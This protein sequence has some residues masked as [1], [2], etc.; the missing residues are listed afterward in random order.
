MIARAGRGAAGLYRYAWYLGAAFQIQD[1]VLNLVGDFEQYGKEPEGDLW[2]GKRTLMLIHVLGACTT[3]ER[4]RL[5]RF[6]ALGRV[7]RTPKQV[8]WVRGLL[9]R[10]GSIDHARRTARRLAGA[11]LLEGMQAFRYA[12]DPA[13]ARFLLEMPLYVVSRN[14]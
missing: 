6:L 12:T 11:A 2:E 10:Y 5:G 7:E 3:A 14:R 4:T 1:D 9:D 13:A 8:A